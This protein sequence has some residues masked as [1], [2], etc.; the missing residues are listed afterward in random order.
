MPHDDHLFTPE[1]VDEQIDWLERASHA[2]PPTSNTRVIQGLHRLYET[3][4]A[5]AHSVD[6]VWQRLQE[7]G[8]VPAL[9]PQRARRSGTP[10]RQPDSGPPPH[11]YAPAALAR[12]GLSTRLLTIAAAVLLVVVVSGLVAGLVLVRQQ[13]PAVTNQPTVKPG[14]TASAAQT[15]TPA[16]SSCPTRSTATAEAW[17]LF[18][19]PPDFAPG[20]IMGTINNGPVTTLSDFHYPLDISSQNN[21]VVPWFM[22]WSP[23]AHYLAVGFSAYN[24]GTV[25]P[26]IIDTTTHATTPITFATGSGFAAWSGG[27]SFAW[28]DNQTLLL[29]SGG[30]T[31]DQGSAGP[32]YGYNVNTK[33]LTLLPGVHAAEGVVRCSTLFYLELTPPT[34]FLGVRNNGSYNVYQGSA[35][36]HRYDLK[37]DKEIGQAIPIG[38][39]MALSRQTTRVFVGDPSVPVW[40]ISPD[41]TLL[42]YA[43]E[44]ISVTVLETQQYMIADVDGANAKSFASPRQGDLDTWQMEIS[45]NDQYVLIEAGADIISMNIDGSNYRAYGNYGASFIIINAPVWLPDSSGFDVVNTHQQGQ[46]FADPYVS[47]YLLNTPPGSDGYV[48]GTQV[49]PEVQILAGLP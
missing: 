47:R 43:Q 35:L 17:S 29:F 22:A 34:D 36:L 39:T 41:G 38:P 4:Q 12:R 32:S 49:A 44:A 28:A 40:N 25:Y 9:Q 23:D 31:N 8:A 15:T 46:T 5:D 16:P 13:K 18:E 1:E 48:P 3:E 33:Q 20:Q 26:Y 27:R 30:N 37:T 14:Q 11:V 42:V 45:P 21:P 7:R 6:T 19:T 2:Q 10:R 24:L